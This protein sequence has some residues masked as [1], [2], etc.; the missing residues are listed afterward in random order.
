MLAGSKVSNLANLECEI[1]DVD[2]ELSSQDTLPG[3]MQAAAANA[4]NTMLETLADEG[5]ML[6]LEPKMNVEISVPT[7]RVGDVLSDLTVRRGSVDDV[8]MARY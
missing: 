3:A 5:R 1:M 4:V 8:A 7:G 2:S 6:V